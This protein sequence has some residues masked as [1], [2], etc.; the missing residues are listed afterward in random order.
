[1]IG[2]IKNLIKK[3]LIYFYYTGKPKS[4]NPISYLRN[5][6]NNNAE[7]KIKNIN[8]GELYRFLSQ[9]RSRSGSTGC[10]FIDYYTIWENLNKYKPSIILECGSGIST[11]VFAYYVH[12]QKK[13]G[14]DIKLISMESE[15][16]WHKQVI[17][18]F[19]SDLINYVTF[20]CS[21]RKETQYNGLL[22]AH[23]EEIPNLNYDFIF[24]D[25]PG[26]RK[27]FNDK[28]SP[29]CFNS[30][31]INL[32]MNNSQ[33]TISGLIDQRIDTVWKLKKLIPNGDIQYNVFKKCTFL[34]DL[35]QGQLL[36][37]IKV[38][39]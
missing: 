38:K 15:K 6:I 27:I 17:E 5:F 24:I 29:K 3:L 30:D 28:L 25:G 22:G 32:L 18:I 4:I 2:K 13:D 10:E 23:Y 34:K 21:K 35:K 16:D 14:K 37:K 11:V 8:N 9:T 39:N 7:E 26:L 33:M 12:S 36:S 20:K 31:V 19:P 1:M